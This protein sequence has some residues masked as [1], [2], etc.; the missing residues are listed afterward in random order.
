MNH[1]ANST[2]QLDLMTAS[3]ILH[4]PDPEH[5]EDLEHQEFN[6]LFDVKSIQRDGIGTAVAAA[7]ASNSGVG[8]A[9][10]PYA[11]VSSPSCRTGRAL[12]NECGTPAI[13]C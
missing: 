3:C 7:T 4:G 2:S 6:E 8:T 5:A 1:V 12:N 10:E 13:H 11:D 9:A